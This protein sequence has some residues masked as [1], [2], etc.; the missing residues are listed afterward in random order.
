[1]T[2]N[3][4]RS[5]DRRIK[6]TGTGAEESMTGRVKNFDAKTLTASGKPLSEA[7]RQAMPWILTAAERKARIRE[8][9]RSIQVA[10]QLDR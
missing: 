6:S 10:E 9:L 8:T 4:D 5:R 2:Q 7:A 3:R 1:M